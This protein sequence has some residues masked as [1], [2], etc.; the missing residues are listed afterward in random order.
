MT[1]NNRNAESP[2]KGDS[3]ILGSCSVL[4]RTFD[5]FDDLA[6]TVRGWN[7]NWIQL[8]RGPLRATGVSCRTPIYAFREYLRVSPKAYLQARRLDGFRNELRQVERD[9]RIS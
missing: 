1:S 5:D 3:W 4:R 6:E 8:D 7:L 2:E 9:I